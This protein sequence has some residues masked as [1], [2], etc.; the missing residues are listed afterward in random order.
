[1]VVLGLTLPGGGPITAVPDKELRMNK[2]FADAET[3]LRA[4]VDTCPKAFVE[5]RAAVV[6]LKRLNP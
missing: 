5:Y 4:A 2:V 6:E 1:M 3:A